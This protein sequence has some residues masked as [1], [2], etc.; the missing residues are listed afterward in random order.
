MNSAAKKPKPACTVDGVKLYAVPGRAGLYVTDDGSAVYREPHD[1]SGI[2]RC[3]EYITRN[4]YRVVRTG[5]N[6]TTGVQILVAL[7]FV[8]PQPSATHI[9]ARRNGIRTDN[10]PENLWW[11]R[12]A[13]ANRAAF[14]RRNPPTERQRMLAARPQAAQR[15]TEAIAAAQTP[16]GAWARALLDFQNI[17]REQGARN[18]LEGPSPNSGE[19]DDL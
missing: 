10:R 18:P 7:T 13:E 4:G 1:G 19:F 6:T 17:H 14:D 2:T 16:G 5:R 12:K 11:A 8:G 9:V 3:R 15:K